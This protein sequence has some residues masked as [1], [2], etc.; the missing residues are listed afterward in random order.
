MK[1]KS[2]NKSEIIQANFVA[3]LER[4]RKKGMEKTKITMNQKR[5]SIKVT[6]MQEHRMLLICVLVPNEKA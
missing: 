1:A 5:K 4:S 6:S 2:I 3:K